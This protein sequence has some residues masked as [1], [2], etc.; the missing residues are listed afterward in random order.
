MILYRISQPMN[1]ARWG[2]LALSGLGLIISSVFFPWLFA[3]EKM[4]TRCVMLL[5]V[6]ALVTEPLLRY[7]IQ[8]VDFTVRGFRFWHKSWQENRER[9]ALKK[10]IEQMIP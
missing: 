3:L 2:I 8:A 6:F 10:K 1:T 7:G 5:G 4:T 9:R